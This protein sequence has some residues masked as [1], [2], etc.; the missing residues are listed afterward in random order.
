MYDAV[1]PARVR[2]YQIGMG[3][4][5]DIGTLDA[6]EADETSA[7]KRLLKTLQEWLQNGTDCS[8]AALKKVM[9]ISIVGRKDIASTLPPS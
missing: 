3:L 6:I 7:N 5:V 4:E 8:W 2:W 9:E 1:Y